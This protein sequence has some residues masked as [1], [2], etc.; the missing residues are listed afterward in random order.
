[1][2]LGDALE[3]LGSLEDRP[4]LELADAGAVDLLPRGLGRSDGI[5][6]CRL[7]RGAPLGELL[8]GDQHVGPAL[9]EVDPHPVARAEQGQA[10]AD[11]PPRAR[12]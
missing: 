12:R 1:V 7:E 4:V 8:V 2:G 10:L 6:A 9:A 5:A 3:L 11:A